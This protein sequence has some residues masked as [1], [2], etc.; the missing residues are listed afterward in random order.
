MEGI[1]DE[2]DEASNSMSLV[3]KFSTLQGGQEVS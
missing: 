2:G 1:G 3:L